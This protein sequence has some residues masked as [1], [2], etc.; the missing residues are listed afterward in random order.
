VKRSLTRFI[1]EKLKRVVNQ[2]KSKSAPLRQ[3]SFLGFFLGARGQIRWT[4]KAYQRFKL[5][6]REITSR[7]RGRNVDDVI[8]EL[9]R[10]VIGWL[11]YFGISHT[12]KEVMVLDRWIR[13]RVRLYYWK[14]WKQPRT[15]RR[16]LIALGILPE[17]TRLATRR[18]KGYWRMSTNSILQRALNNAWLEKQ[19]VPDFRKQW[20]ALHYGPK[21]RV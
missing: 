3:C 17:E 15:R 9:R 14:Q 21:A 7:N 11:N 12:F 13:R 5:R 20:I 16:R 8:L 10:Y 1:E 19:G 6:I 4:D 18:R 2:T